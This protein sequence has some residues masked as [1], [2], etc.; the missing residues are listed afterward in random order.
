[1]WF[2]F[3]RPDY[4][5]FGRSRLVDAGDASPFNRGWTQGFGLFALDCRWNAERTESRDGIHYA[6]RHRIIVNGAVKYWQGET[7]TYEDVC[8]LAQQPLYASMTFSKAP[9]EKR[10]GILSK[11]ESTKV[12]DGTIFNAVVTGSA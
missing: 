3:W 1:M 8:G 12:G 7:I 5:W 2:R 11:G 6:T 10:Q 4:L 9:G